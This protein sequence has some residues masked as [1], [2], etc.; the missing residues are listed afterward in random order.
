MKQTLKELNL[1]KNIHSSQDGQI[2]RRQRYTT[3]IYIVLL[4]LSV[5]IIVVF[6]SITGQTTHFSLNSPSLDE[7]N[8][9]YEKYPSTLSCPC[10]QT[11]IDYLLLLNIQPEYHKVCLSEYV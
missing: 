6:T 11:A 9:L 1:F 7:F 4:F 3:R 8:Q 2:L 10:N 5:I